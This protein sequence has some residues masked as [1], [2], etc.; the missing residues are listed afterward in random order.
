MLDQLRLAAYEGNES[1]AITVLREAT[2]IALWEYARD[3]SLVRPEVVGQ[4]LANAS[5]PRVWRCAAMLE[6]CPKDWEQVDR[7]R[8]SYVPGNDEVES[9]W[10]LRTPVTQRMWLHTFDNAVK[11]PSSAD[12]ESLE[13]GEDPFALPVETILWMESLLFCNVLSRSH[14]FAAA[15]FYQGQE[16]DVPDRDTWL[17][18]FGGA[19]AELEYQ[20]EAD[21]F[22]LPT[23]KE[24]EQLASSPPEVLDPWA[25]Y[26]ANAEDRSHPVGQKG[27]NRWGLWDVWGNVWEWCWG[28]VRLA[29]TD[30]VHKPIRGGSYA[31][32]NWLHKPG[33]I[34]ADKRVSFIGMRP[35]RRAPMM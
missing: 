19:E 22:R 34:A 3:H 25:W 29:N 32:E 1:D 26:G 13:L 17:M 27:S 7:S 5:D 2:D 14:K 31:T 18:S 35:V 28:E 33:L 6:L 11:N 10:V 16:I 8:W 9:L 21:G 24:W 23:V 12:H 20:K 30:M 15:Y 4:V